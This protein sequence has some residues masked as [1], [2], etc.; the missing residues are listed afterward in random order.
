MRAA[1]ARGAFYAQV[2]RLQVTTQVPR[3]IN[4]P[5]LDICRVSGCHPATPTLQ[6]T[7]ANLLHLG[8]HPIPDRGCDILSSRWSTRARRHLPRR[9]NIS[10]VQDE[11]EKLH[12]AFRIGAGVSCFSC[13]PW[14]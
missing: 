11:Q 8:N 7:V 6:G 14:Y 5:D 2:L 1:I 13:K 9:S 4:V 3:H 10:V 12:I